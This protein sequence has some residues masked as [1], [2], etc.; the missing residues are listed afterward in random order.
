MGSPIPSAALRLTPQP[1]LVLIDADTISEVHLIEILTTFIT[2]ES[3]CQCVISANRPLSKC[4]EWINLHPAHVEITQ[5]PL[6]ANE[7]DRALMRRSDELL[8][9][10]LHSA[11]LILTQ[12]RD[13]LEI[14]LRWHHARR[15][16]F[17]VP[18]RDDVTARAL[19]KR[20]QRQGV[21]T[22]SLSELSL[23]LSG[24]ISRVSVDV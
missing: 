16:A 1:L 2:V 8:S 11:A 23:N 18:L 5:A 7:A 20:C 22:L 15:P 19:L 10:E 3:Q 9:Q 6:G 21:S 14:A 12:D 17:I 24:V 13:L 4:R